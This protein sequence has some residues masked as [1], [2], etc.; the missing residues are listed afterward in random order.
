MIANFKKR[1]YGYECDLYGHMHNTNYLNILESARSEALRDVDMPVERL[2]AL[3]WHVY[4]HK[5]EMEFV[6]GA[7]IDDEVEVRS[8]VLRVNRLRSTWL[9]EMY[10]AEGELCFRAHVHVV[11]VFDGKPTRVP[12][13]I[14][15]HFVRLADPEV[16]S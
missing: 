13:D 16:V 9:Q 7:R 2:L 12:D 4:I 6:L 14:W 10:N 1:I 3:N 11:H 8:R 5:V 15:Q